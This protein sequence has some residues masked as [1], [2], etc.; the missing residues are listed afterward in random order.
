MVKF[1]GK[2]DLYF[3]LFLILAFVEKLFVEGAIIG[4]NCTLPD[5]Q[6]GLFLHLNA[7]EP[8]IIRPNEIVYASCNK[9][10]SLDGSPE[11]ICRNGLWTPNLPVCQPKKCSVVS[12]PNGIITSNSSSTEPISHKTYI[13]IK[14]SPGFLLD[15][16]SSLFCNFGK[17]SSEIPSCVPMHCQPD[18]VDNGILIHE[19][20]VVQSSKKIPHEDTIMVSCINGYTVSTDFSHLTCQFG[21]WSSPFPSCEP[22]PCVPHKVPN[23]R[24]FY[25]G[26]DISA[27]T[28]VHDSHTATVICG[29]DYILHGEN[30]LTCSKGVWSHDF[31]SCLPKFCSSQLVAQGEVL[32]FGKELQKETNIEHRSSVYISCKPGYV[33][34]GS[35]KVTCSYGHWS[36]NFPTCVPSSCHAQTVLHGM[37]KY[38]EQKLINV[39]STL[40]DGL[41]SHSHVVSIKCLEG[42]K[43][44]GTD[45]LTCKFGNWSDKFPECHPAKCDTEAVENGKVVDDEGTEIRTA[46]H[47]QQVLI[48]C[49]NGYR[50]PR[51]NAASMIKCYYGEWTYPFPACVPENCSANAVLN[52]QVSYNDSVV[53]FNMLDPKPLQVPHKQYVEVSCM[54]GFSTTDRTKVMCVSGKWL[55]RFPTCYPNSCHAY[56]VANGITHI[57]EQNSV[58]KEWGQLVPHGL[59]VNITCKIGHELSGPSNLKCLY[60]NWTGDFPECT[61]K[62]CPAIKVKNGKESYVDDEATSFVKHDMF[63]HISCDE[64]YQLDGA[65]KIKCSQGFWCSPSP[66]CEPKQCLVKEVTGGTIQVNGKQLVVYDKPVDHLSI[67][68]MKCH[69][70][71]V[72]NGIPKVQCLFGKWSSEFPTCNEL[73]CE[74][75]TIM[76]G[77]LK[78]VSS[79]KFVNAGDTVAANVS[80]TVECNPDHSLKGPPV[81]AKCDMAKWTNE[82][83]SCE[84]NTYCRELKVDKEVQVNYNGPL[85]E[86]SVAQFAC[87]ND[88]CFKS[89]D[90]K[91]ICGKN[92][93]WIIGNIPT[94][95]CGS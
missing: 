8:K 72:V 56:T 3:C 2:M 41:V 53:E 38:L 76:N 94:C 26:Q 66:K 34:I 49:N 48:L 40:S 77:K 90:E 47:S 65:S 69:H 9:G 4:G 35:T 5:I 80:L 32:Y 43:L 31:P 79:G 30:A 24:V 37:V 11:I 88:L 27:E 73:V 18:D 59:S 13:Y 92:G 36:Q 21:K 91:A 57:I 55:Q 82:L 44:Q 78:D 74:A 23:G 86:G 93:Q 51:E 50:L 60:G 87:K 20:V 89:N 54:N 7:D 63:L 95:D 10:Y 14:C 39:C 46:V 61:P 15:G 16:T 68:V 84:K 64:G 52:G 71:F 70:S 22:E 19:G 29:S 83:Q 75:P 6:N 45:I 17:W 1:Q 42:F 25:S 81:V 12:I 67:A 62:S 33:N 58:L 85:S 28:K